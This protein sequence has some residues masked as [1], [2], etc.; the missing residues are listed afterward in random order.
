[1]TKDQF[2]HAFNHVLFIRMNSIYGVEKPCTIPMS[3]DYYKVCHDTL[4]F[5]RRQ[6]MLEETKSID[7]ANE[8]A[9]YMINYTLEMLSHIDLLYDILFDGECSKIHEELSEKTGYVYS[10][11]SAIEQYSNIGNMYF[12]YEIDEKNLLKSIEKVVK[13]QKK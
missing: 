9:R 8:F 6:Y 11:S 4:E 3:N 10:Y 12:S 13:L 7:N 2:M 1:M 5:V